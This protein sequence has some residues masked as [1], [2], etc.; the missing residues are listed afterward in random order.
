MYLQ[1]QEPSFPSNKQSNAARLYKKGK[2][3]TDSIFCSI[4]SIDSVEIRYVSRTS[5]VRVPII[6]MTDIRVTQNPHNMSY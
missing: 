6:T 2:G 4:K 1:V 5:Q 3:D